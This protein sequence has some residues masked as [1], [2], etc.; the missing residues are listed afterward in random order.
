MTKVNKLT[1]R[2]DFR[3]VVSSAEM[4]PS[5]Q[6]NLDRPNI[7]WLLPFWKEGLSIVVIRNKCYPDQEFE[8]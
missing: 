7:N 5:G 8:F 4:V 3:I 1:I 6:N 2:R